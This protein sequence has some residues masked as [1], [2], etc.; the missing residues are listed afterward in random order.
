MIGRHSDSECSGDASARAP[1]HR[2]A[3]RRVLRDAV[4]RSMRS[5]NELIGFAALR[6]SVER[7]LRWCFGVALVLVAYPANAREGEPRL[8]VRFSPQISS[9]DA[10]RLASA[11]RGQLRD[12][13]TVDVTAVSP[14][15]I[16]RQPEG[17]EVMTESSR[18]ADTVAA[19]C[20][21]DVDRGE[22]GI[23]LRFADGAG[24]RA[25]LPRV[26]ARGGEIGASE[27]ATIVRAFVVAAA[28]HA[29]KEKDADMTPPAANAAPVTDTKGASSGEELRSPAPTTTKG[30]ESSA[31]PEPSA[32]A[33]P[34]TND[35]AAAPGTQAPAPAPPSQD[36]GND[37]RERPSAAKGADAGWRVRV[38]ALYTG[39]A[40]ASELPWQ[41]GARAEGAFAFLPGFYGGVTY[42]FHPPREIGSNAVSVN[43][44]RHSGALFVG[45][46]DAGRTFVLGADAAVGLDDTVRGLARTSAA[47]S[48]T[49]DA[50]NVGTTFALRLHGRWRVPEGRGLGL[51]VAPTVELAPS[52][53]RMVVENQGASALLAP[54][55]V[56]FRLDVGATFDGF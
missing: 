18:G 24:R 5:S 20:I 11:I 51:D 22:A 44:S 46:E 7:M 25:G 21:V 23:V 6:A 49:G 19:T 54:A 30:V 31:A 13:A 12:T 35:R 56:R 38:A 41:S 29:T 42:A 48:P 33:E 52:E 53:R 8:V 36:R 1:H 10:A 34:A 37:A 27:A 14:K 16:P 32:T 55:V 39:T 26:V 50:V 9:A 15:P 43:V 2:R 40:Y 17:R 3:R 4:R 28:T 47:F 45:L